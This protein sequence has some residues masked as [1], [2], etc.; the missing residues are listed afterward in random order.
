MMPH[1]L[2]R[3]HIEGQSGFSL[4]ETMVGLTV[5]LITVL[6]ITQTFS[7]F[8]SQRQ[9]TTTGSDAQ[10][11]G[12]FAMTTL[13]QD[14]RR[15]GS[16]FASARSLD[17]Q[18][19]HSLI[20][21]GGGLP[22]GPANNF[23][24]TAVS[25]VDGGNGGSDTVIVRSASNFL[26]S[27]PTP[28]TGVPT[29]TNERWV[30][31]GRGFDIDTSTGPIM[32]LLVQAT[33]EHCMLGAIT[34]TS[35][36]NE[37]KQ[38]NFDVGVTSPEYNASN[39]YMTSNGWPL[40]T[41]YDKGQVFILSKLAAGAGITSRAYGVDANHQLFVSNY[42]TGGSPTSEVLAA[43]VVSLQVQYGV[44]SNISSPNDRPS[45]IEPV[46]A[47]AT[48]LDSN[49]QMITQPS[50]GDVRRIKAIRLIA[51]VRTSRRDASIVTTA[52]SDNHTTNYGPCAY[53]DDTVTEPAPSIDLRSAPGDTE[54]QHYRYKVY[55]T[56]VPLRNVMWS[57]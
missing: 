37:N 14:I 42:V 43:E 3:P 40:F 5:G 54:W 9:I 21:P 6:A 28:I 44:V 7:A 12:W 55:S 52:C 10:G 27:I 8:E 36:T 26:G 32:A 45:W 30:S 24:T 34:S 1:K 15:A 39:S 49:G 4:V 20:D 22:V 48:T 19:V 50:Y 47:W 41:N 25:I 2:N 33:S 29:N 51:V 11:N 17:C 56:I 16:G 18:N 46:G 57:H 53:Q 13:V 23:S 38:L 31:V 35:N